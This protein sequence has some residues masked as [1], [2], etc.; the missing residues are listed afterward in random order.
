MSPATTAQNAEVMPATENGVAATPKAISAANRKVP[1]KAFSS[2]SCSA[3]STARPARANRYV[4]GK[5][6]I[7]DITGGAATASKM[8]RPAATRLAQYRPDCGPASGAAKIATPVL[9]MIAGCPPNKALTTEFTPTTTVEEATG[10]RYPCAIRNP[11]PCTLPRPIARISIGKAM[12]TMAGTEKL[13]SARRAV[14]N[15]H[16]IGVFANAPVE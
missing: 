8:V 15:A 16:W 6:P 9:A 7:T 4:R 14:E 3:D 1:P 2:A 10:T 13:T 11:M 5:T 12:A